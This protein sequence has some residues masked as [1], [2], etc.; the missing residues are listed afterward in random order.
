MISD[1][2]SNLFYNIKVEQNTK[3]KFWG[4]AGRKNDPECGE[5]MGWM[6][7][8]SGRATR[9][10]GMMSTLNSK[11]LLVQFVR[12]GSSSLQSDNK[13]EDVNKRQME[14]LLEGGGS[15]GREE[16]REVQLPAN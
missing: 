11:G 10:A 5:P 2:I 13:T 12:C 6:D 14:E 16:G 15:E 3:L 1:L 8:R 7:E 4:M 9:W